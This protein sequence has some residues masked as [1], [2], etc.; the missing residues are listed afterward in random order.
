MPRDMARARG[1]P[2]LGPMSAPHV[3]ALCRSAPALQQ[4]ERIQKPA[5]V[6]IAVDVALSKHT[7]GNRPFASVD[8]AI[9]VV[10]VARLANELARRKAAHRARLLAGDRHAACRHALALLLVLLLG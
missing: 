8:H 7:D 3:C 5:D 10:E 9:D 1:A 6:R 2:C 4:G